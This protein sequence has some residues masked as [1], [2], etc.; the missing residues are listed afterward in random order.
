MEAIRKV[1]NAGNAEAV[2]IP[3]KIIKALGIKK[4]DLLHVDFSKIEIRKVN[5]NSASSELNN[6]PFNYC[7]L[8]LPSNSLINTFKQGVFA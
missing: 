4:G 5:K 7:G 8:P 3:K 6:G 1:I 2:S